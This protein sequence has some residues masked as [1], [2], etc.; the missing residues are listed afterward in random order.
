[1]NIQ[2]KTCTKCGEKKP[3]SEFS[4]DK[5]AKIGVCSDCKDCRNNHQRTETSKK[6][7]QKYYKNYFKSDTGKKIQKKAQKKYREKITYCCRDCGNRIAHTTALYGQGRCKKCS[8]T[9]EVRKA[10]S[11]AQTGKKESKA[12]CLKISKAM[13]GKKNPRYIN[14]LSVVLYNRNFS[15]ELK[16]KIRCRDKHQCQRCGKT[17]EQELKKIGRVLSVHHIDYNKFNCQETNLI[18]TCMKCNIKA[19]GNKKFDRSFWY[20]YYRY[21]IENK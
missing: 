14:G 5:S 1:M 2:Y 21:K 8:R 18:T 4:K 10:V 12:F 16:L 19:N 17:E 20:S 6:Y 15:D 11:K 13:K 7:R 3:L 9:L